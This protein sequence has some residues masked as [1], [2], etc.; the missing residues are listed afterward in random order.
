[1][2][3]LLLVLFELFAALDGFIGVLLIFF[4]ALLDTLGTIGTIGTGGKGLGKDNAGALGKL[5]GVAVF[6]G[7]VGV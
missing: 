4:G 6:I 2:A 5:S 3:L 7:G 1:V